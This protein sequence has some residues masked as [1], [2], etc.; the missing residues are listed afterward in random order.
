M[1]FDD[2]IKTVLDSPVATN[3]DRAVRWRQ[4]IDLLSRARP[5]SDQALVER[6]LD[7]AR[8]DRATVPDQVRAATARSI[9]GRPVDPRLVALFAADKLEVAAP[10]LAG[11]T[12]DAEARTQVAAVAS[13]EVRRFFFALAGSELPAA[14]EP[15]ELDQLLDETLP[16]LEAGSPAPSIGEMVARIERRRRA[17]DPEAAPPVDEPTLFRWESD[18]GGAIAWVEGAPRAALI[19][20]VLAGHPGEALLDEGS[21]AMLARRAPFVDLP[22]AAGEPFAGDWR[23]SGAPAFSTG[24]GRFIG[25]RGIARRIDLAPPPRPRRRGRRTGA[26]DADSIRELVHEIKT[27]L[28][29]IIGFA[30]IIDGQFLGPAHRNYRERAAGIVVQA[31]SLLAAVEDLDLAAKL[32]S[33]RSSPNPGTEFRSLLPAI[34]EQLGIHGAQRGIS[35]EWRPDGRSARCVLAPELAERMVRRFL[36][37]VIDAS[38]DGEKLALTVAPVAGQC[39]IAVNRPASLAAVAEAEL[40]D[41]SFGGANGQV[42]GLGFAFRLVRGLARTVG[43]DLTVE[44]ERF[45]LTLPARR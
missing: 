24:E 12:L 17:P 20:R 42:I 32:Q 43:G 44:R 16:P 29:A 30:E 13:D 18:P 19:G 45:V 10:L 41:P 1:R 9:A 22:M 28:N 35:V 11:T 5:D 39:A 21:R 25:Y 4:L 38:G 14:P 6:A 8:A 34:V 3:R 23:V 7:M 31:R 36:C 40:F 15:L 37:A 26:D 27:P 33:G 2:R